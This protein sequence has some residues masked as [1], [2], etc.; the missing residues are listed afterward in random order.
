MSFLFAENQLEVAV[1][2]LTYNC[3]ELSNKLLPIIKEN[4][5]TN[6][7]IQIV[8]ADNASTDGTP[9]FLSEKFPELPLLKFDKNW[10]FAEGYNKAVESINCKY[11]VLL[12]CDV[13]VAPGWLNPMLEA[14][15]KDATIGAVQP[16][17]MSYNNRD[18]FEYAGASGGYIDVLGFPFCRGRLFKDTE[19]DNGQYDDEKDLFWSGGCCFMVNREVY[20][21]LG[22]LDPDFFAHMEEIDFCWRLQKND[23]K[24]RVVPK[25]IVYHIGGF[26]LNYNHPFK[27]YL[28]SR[29]NLSM[30]MKNL[31][32]NNLIWCLPA[33][34]LVDLL[35]VIYL[36]FTDGYKQ[37]FAVIKGDFHFLKS[38][39]KWWLK[40]DGKEKSFNDLKGVYKSSIIIEYFLK[41]RKTFN[42]IVK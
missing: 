8:L 2:I 11:A 10:G 37:A 5:E 6:S 15:Q 21:Q 20:L 14:M 31:T 40:R 13:E 35:A 38:I 19:I 28:N 30:L 29:N 17:I 36:L 18:S 27:L 1:V 4:T 34:V 32:F 24:I 41:K 26:K 42:E 16:K 3:K 23:Y 12:S 22:G 7:N 25:A 33:R 9:E 39:R